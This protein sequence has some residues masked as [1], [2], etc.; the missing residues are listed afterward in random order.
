MYIALVLKERRGQPNIEAT[1]KKLVNL[2]YFEDGT[3]DE[4]RFKCISCDTC[5]KKFSVVSHMCTYHGLDKNDVQKWATYKDSNILKKNPGSVEKLVLTRSL[6]HGV[7]QVGKADDDGDDED[8]GEAAEVVSEGQAQEVDQKEEGSK[9]AQEAS[10]PDEGRQKAHEESTDT[11]F[12]I[13]AWIKVDSDGNVVSPLEMAETLP[14][15]GKA[16]V[17]TAL[18]K[19]TAPGTPSFMPPKPKAAPRTPA[20]FG[21]VAPQTPPLHIGTASSGSAPT[22]EASTQPTTDTHK[23]DIGGTPKQA[24][25]SSVMSPL[26]KSIEDIAKGLESVFKPFAQASGVGRDELEVEGPKLIIKEAAKA[27]KLEE[28]GQHVLRMAWPLPKNDEVDLKGFEAYLEGPVGQVQ[29]SVDQNTRQIRYMYGLFELP[30]TF[31]HEGF[32]ARLYLSGNAAEVQALPILSPKNPHSA[33]LATALS[34]FLEYLQQ[35]ADRAKH[36]EASRCITGLKKDFLK[37]LQCKVNKARK[38]RK[39]ANRAHTTTKLKAM[40]PKEVLQKAI[41][42][43]MVALYYAKKMHNIMDE[44]DWRLRHVANSIMAGLVFANAYAGRPG[45]WQSLLRKEVE[46]VVET[47]ANM[48]VM[49]HHKTVDTHGVAGRPIPSGNREAMSVLLD[50]HRKDATYFFD[51]AKKTSKSLVCSMSKLLKKWSQHYFPQYQ[52]VG[53][54][55]QRKLM[56]T[57]TQQV[58]VA[59]K[60]FDLVCATDKHRTKTGLDNYVG[61]DPEVDAQNGDCMYRANIGD[62]VEWPSPEAMK[63]GKAK[64][65]ED[66]QAMVCRASKKNGGGE[67][68]EEEDEEGDADSDGGDEAEG[69]KGC[70]EEGEEAEAGEK[71]GGSE[72]DGDDEGDGEPVPLAAAFAAMEDEGEQKDAK[73]DKKGKN[74]ED[75]GEHKEAKE[76]KKDKK[77]EGEG[78]QKDAKD[79]KKDKKSKRGQDAGGSAATGSVAKERCKEKQAEGGEVQGSVKVE[80]AGGGEVTSMEAAL[81]EVA[82]EGEGKEAAMAKEESEGVKGKEGAKKRAAEGPELSGRALKAR[83][84]DPI[85]V[86]SLPDEV[87]E[88]LIQ[89]HDKQV[90]KEGKAKGELARD[91]FFPAMACVGFSN[92]PLKDYPGCDADMIRAVIVQGLAARPRKDEA[93][94]QEPKPK[95]PKLGEVEHTDKKM[96]PG[97]LAICSIVFG[98][99]CSSIDGSSIAFSIARIGIR[100]NGIDIAMACIGSIGPVF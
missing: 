86:D 58:E 72:E 74:K 37:P 35:G 36:T 32:W 60:M 51:P 25:G 9:G 93:K 77:K 61:E 65:L 68:E 55:L 19:S 45:E 92:G 88:W 5:L 87:K 57:G 10:V 44:P 17:G 28:R 21:K 39:T 97:A 56:H 76:G 98:V 33:N 34:H 82:N 40:P 78:R 69:D 71:D 11:T 64:A 50:I 6:L 96:S 66:L 31:S 18:A 13:R 52:E 94:P 62:P 70:S 16:L 12:W 4:M 53:A 95:A 89:Y 3:V 1:E 59:K 14:S 91:A 47:G 8:V 100:S 83:R 42:E 85:T 84:S 63:A 38:A 48:I 7:T 20:H 90:A 23:A 41:H 2:V 99:A 67:E 80:Q 79:G 15:G 26:R 24:A 27:W 46:E 30:E 75:E 22:G 43:S 49:K 73:V 54:T 81:E 29:S